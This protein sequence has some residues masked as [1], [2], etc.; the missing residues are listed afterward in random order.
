LAKPPRDLARSLL[1]TY[2]VTAS[3]WGH[4]FYFQAER[5]AGLFINTLFHYRG[6][7]K[8]LLQE[9]VLMPNHFHV[10]FTPTG[11]ILERVMPIIKG[12]FSHRARK[13]L[14]C[15]CRFGN[16]DTWTIGFATEMILNRTGNT[17]VRIR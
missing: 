17:S 10:F 4:R 13:E 7:G 3:S 14:G 5:M 16:A 6:E 2:F 11:V 1:S 9:L 8:Y 15:R 12:G